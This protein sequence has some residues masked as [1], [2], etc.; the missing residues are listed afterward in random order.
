MSVS[1]VAR[2]AIVGAFAGVAWKAVEPLLQRAF[3]SPYSD[4]GLVSRIVSPGPAAAY[5]T[6]FVGGATF[7]GLFAHFGG[8]G[9]RQAVAVA[10]VEN[11]ALWPFVWVLQRVHPDVQSGRWPKPF[12]DPGSI[13][14]SYSGHVLFGVLLGTLLD[15]HAPTS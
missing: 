10:M 3:D 14:V 8:R 9:A 11:T 4:A 5:A 15:S 7:G 2:G 6:Q 12:A 13:A 1:R